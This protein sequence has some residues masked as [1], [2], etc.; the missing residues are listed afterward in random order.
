MLFLPDDTKR[1]WTEDVSTGIH[2]QINSESALTW[3]Q[4]RKSCQQ[5][6]ADLLS[7]TETQEQAYVVGKRTENKTLKNDEVVGC[8]V[9]CLREQRGQGVRVVGQPPK[10]DGLNRPS[11]AWGFLMKH[12]SQTSLAVKCPHASTE[13]HMGAPAAPAVGLRGRVSSAHLCA[14]ALKPHQGYGLVL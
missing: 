9:V 10:G 5:Q 6:N 13:P 14:K 4:A 11:T 12:C 1:F 3:H 8:L 2:Y 7:I